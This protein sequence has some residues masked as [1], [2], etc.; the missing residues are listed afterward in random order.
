MIRFAWLQFRTQVAIA[1]GALAVVAGVLALTG[2][3]LVHL[4]D[5]TVVNCA[6]QHDCSTATN[7]FTDTDGALQV[8]LDFV[9]LVAPLLIGMF[10]GAPLVSRELEAGTFR[11]A[12]TQG[13]T[14][15]AG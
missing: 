10:W 4:Y 1:A 3:N 9:L 12:W 13:I 6:A 8:F 11:L 14:G 2:P 15:P 5:T 7:V